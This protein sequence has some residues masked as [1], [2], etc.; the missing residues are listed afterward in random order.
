MFPLENFIDTPCGIAVPTSEHAYQAAKF[1]DEDVQRQIAVADDGR[2]S[3][4]LAHELQAQ[5]AQVIT[6]WH[7]RKFGVMLGFVRA[8]FAVNDSIAEKLMSTADELLVEGNSWGDRYWGVS[9]AG[10]SRGKNKLGIVLMTV[11]SE[12]I[13]R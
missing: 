8:K 13:S 5:G 1:V 2:M 10:S 11:R 12:L 7:Q 6:G 3:K 4:E 9:P